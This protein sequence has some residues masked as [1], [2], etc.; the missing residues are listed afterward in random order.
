MPISAHARITLERVASGLQKPTFLTTPSTDIS[1]VFILEKDRARVRILDRDTNTLLATPFLTISDVSTGGERGLLGM[2]FHPDYDSNG[3]FYL[4]FTDSDGDTVIRRY[5]VDPD[6]PDLADAG[7]GVNVLTISQPQANHNGGWIGFG[8]D[9]FLYGATGDG[10]SS[11]DSGSGHS[12]GTGNAQDLTGNL[13]GKLLRL[14]IDGDDFPGDSGRNYA[15]PADNPFVG[16]S[17]D[18]EIWAFGLRNPWRCSF[19]R[20]T[21][22]LWIADVGQGLKEEL[23]VIPAGLGAG[24]NFGWRLREGT[25]ATPSDGIGG[26]RPDGS[27]DPIYEY[28][29]GSGPLQG[30][31]VTGGYV[32]RGPAPELRG[33]YFFA[34]F[35]TKHLWSL[36]FDGSA[37]NQHDGSNFK[38]FRD[39]SNDLPVNVGQLNNVASFGEDALGN[40]FIL[41]FDGEIFELVSDSVAPAADSFSVYS[42][43]RAQTDEPLA[44]FGPLVLGEPRFSPAPESEFNVTR[45]KHLALPSSIN[46][47][48]I[49]RPSTSL[50]AYQ[51]QLSPNQAWFPANDSISVRNACGLLSLKVIKPK[52]LLVPGQYRLDAPGSPSATS[53]IGESSVDHLLCYRVQQRRRS[54][55]GSQASSV[56]RDAQVDSEDPLEAR[57]FDLRRP[58]LLCLPTSV[59]GSPV[60]QSGPLAGEPKALAAVG[61]ADTNLGLLCFAT[62][63]SRTEI[64]QFGCAAAVADDPG[65]VIEPRQPRHRGIG[66]DASDPFASRKLRTING[67]SLCLPTVLEP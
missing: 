41:D 25:S 1:R 12:A 28:T 4:N 7:S 15:I 14:D 20:E 16:R 57:R 59:D 60:F 8:P 54:D 42:T 10:G 46:D 67:A 40:L 63:R 29:H 17:G 66:I 30:F 22:D 51:L 2:A 35:V 26:A 53:P 48:E 56:V 3:F 43:R 27:I 5:R 52:W 23:N 58:R 6:N 50:T 32:Y 64:E 62:R 13:L 39:W 24:S 37:A 36:Q 19:D 21:N 55:D 11:N 38:N 31:S 44:R 18:D 9:G 49:L 61:I 34:D 47:G 65:Q 45:A 33:H